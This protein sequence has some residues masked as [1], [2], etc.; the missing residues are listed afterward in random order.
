MTLSLISAYSLNRVIGKDNS[1]PWYYPS[2][3]KHFKKATAGKTVIM[4][5]KTFESKG[6]PKPLPNRRNIVVTQNKDYQT[7]Y[8][9]EI[10][11]SLQEA[12]DLSASDEE[13]F[14]IGG[15]NLYKEALDKVDKIYITIIGKEFSGDT[16]FPEFD[17]NNFDITKETHI[18]EEETKLTF[19]EAYRRKD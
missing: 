16:Y 17:W 15:A 13:V 9:V 11:N 3:L 2:D 5:R 8:S 4:G 10:V 1:I 12:L 14:V 7:P 6:M 18:V 19:I